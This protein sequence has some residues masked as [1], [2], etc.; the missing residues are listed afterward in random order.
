MLLKPQW[1]AVES[2]ELRVLL[3]NRIGGPGQYSGKPGDNRL[4]LPLAGDTCRVALR[5]KGNRISAVERGAAFDA[6]EWEGITTTIDALLQTPPE[7]VGRTISFSGFRVTGWWRGAKS[8][9]QIL[10][11]PPSAPAVPYELGEHPFILEFLLHSDSAWPVLNARRLREHRKLT[12]LLNVLLTPRISCEPRQIE[13]AWAVTRMQSNQFHCEWLQ[14]SYFTDIGPVV[15]DALS[16]PVGDPMEALAPHAYYATA[17]YHDGKPLR[18]PSDLDESIWSYR[19]LSVESRE[20]FD[21]ALFWLDV[22]S[23]QYLG[24]VFAGC[25]EF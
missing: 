10:P 21:R 22:A 25:T 13:H 6:A 11:P 23:R 19:Q 3:E 7:K 2:D 1:A 15:I 24:S 20:S 17:R 8:Q 12:L 5:F 9:V 18:V 16:A 14:Q 4:Y